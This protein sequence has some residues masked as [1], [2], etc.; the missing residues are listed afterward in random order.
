MTERLR[1]AVRRGDLCARFGGDEFVVVCEDITHP[2]EVVAIA[3][4]I[5]EALTRPFM[6]DGTQAFVAVS[7]GIA[8]A[9]AGDTVA[10][11]LIRDAD[12][13]M[14]RAKAS[15]GSRWSI[16]DQVLRDRA[17]ARQESELALR[18]ALDRDELRVYFQPEVAVDG[19]RVSGVEALVRWQRPGVGLV[20]PAEFIPIAEE[21]GLIVPLGAWVLS[22]ACRQGMDL[23]SSDLTIRVNVS[24]RQLREPGLVEAVTTALEDSGLPAERLCVE[25]TES[26][27]LEDGERCVAALEALRAIGVGVALDDFGTGYSTLTSARRLPIDCLKIDRS[28]VA[29]LGR[30]S[31]DESIVA[32]VI[33]LARLLGVTVTAEGVETDDQL[34]R[35]RELGCDTFQG[36]LFA[37]PAPAADIAPLVGFSE[38]A[39]A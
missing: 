11:D 9:E 4:R 32:S 6:L 34:T 25:V 10:G 1:A 30:E 17:V 29:G 8:L 7:I 14:Y 23:P 2:D 13:A 26:V 3:E 33:E 27:L 21:T 12:A 39:A 18:H 19:G 38:A 5:L 28:F 15:G 37:R 24:A 20:S 31:D 36:F 22:E 16:F 35:L